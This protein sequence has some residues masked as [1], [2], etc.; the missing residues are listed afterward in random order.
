MVQ[1][2]L[3]VCC[4]G[5]LLVNDARAAAR[6][7]RGVTILNRGPHRRTRLRCDGKRASRESAGGRSIGRRQRAS[8]GEGDSTKH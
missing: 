3:G 2:F 8:P 1:I 6:C 4:R 5:G 7:R